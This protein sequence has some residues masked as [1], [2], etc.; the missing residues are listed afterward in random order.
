MYLRWRIV[1]KAGREWV[2]RDR[3][4]ASCPGR[5]MQQLHRSSQLDVSITCGG[6]NGEPII[7]GTV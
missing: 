3:C 2:Q 6:D 4:R 7:M 5:Q 1:V